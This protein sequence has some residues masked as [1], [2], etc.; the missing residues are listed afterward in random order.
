MS[1]PYEKSFGLDVRPLGASDENGE[2]ESGS[3]FHLVTPA[4]E[5][6]LEEVT[7]RIASRS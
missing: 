4:E 5:D 2:L 1:V 3:L 7:A 6:E